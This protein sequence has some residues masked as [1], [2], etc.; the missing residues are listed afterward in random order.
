M[1]RKVR[2]RWEKVKRKRVEDNGDAKEIMLGVLKNLEEEM[3]EA[4]RVGKLLAKKEKNKKETTEKNKKP[5]DENE[6]ELKASLNFGEIIAQEMAAKEA[7][8]KPKEEEDEEDEACDEHLSALQTRCPARRNFEM[9]CD[10]I[11][12]DSD[13]C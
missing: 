13:S 8:W 12:S 3:A 1:A 5:E 4:H 7:M 9:R 2:E 6:A 11:T 10:T